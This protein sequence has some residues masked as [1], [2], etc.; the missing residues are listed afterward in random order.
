[1]KRL[2]YDAV[3]FDLDGVV[4]DTAKV[5]ATAW[6]ALFDDYLSTRTLQYNEAFRPFDLEEDYFSY[7]DGKP[8]YD[9]VRS[10]LQSRGIDLA[11]GDPENGPER[12][13]ICGLGNRKD[14]IFSKI[15][16]ENGVEVFESTVR[17]AKELKA[18]QVWRAVASSSKNCRNVLRIAGL[19][20]LFDAM[21]DGVLS[22]EL[23]FKGK[24]EPDIFFKCGELLGV[25]PERTVVIEDA[26]S[27]VQAGRNGGFGL[28]IGID[29]MGLGEVLRQNGADVVVADLLDI[30]PQ[31][32]DS[33]FRMKQ[34][35][36]RGAPCS[37]TLHKR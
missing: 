10:F 16:R 30:G 3:I 20:D 8:R 31:E 25:S 2:Q 28:I 33:W 7:L 23:S 34:K 32:I 36:S 15:L 9:G 12:E 27:G 35:A 13:T 11:Y 5:H 17:L 6:K 37:Q 1:V 21:V 22:A 18:R 29:R 4:T 19:E 26:I 14:R 24:P